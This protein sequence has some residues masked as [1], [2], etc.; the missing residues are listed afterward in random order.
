M[1]EN[2][3]PEQ[4]DAVQTTEGALLVLAGA[5]T[6]KTRV[7]T[8]RIA[9]ILNNHLAMPWQV[10][11]MTFTNKAANEMKTRL[12]NMSDGTWFPNGIWCGTFHAICLR[13]L[14]VHAIKVGLQ[15]NF[16]VY[17][18]DDQKSVIKSLVSA[19]TK[20][21]ADYVEEFS[22]IKDK[23]LV[24]LQNK[25]K[26]FN[27]YNAELRR[28]NAVD[29]GDI[30]L[31]VLE[32]FDKYPD[33]LK[34]YQ[35]QFKYIL[36]DEFQ[37][38]NN[39]QMEFLAMLTRDIENPNIC[40]VG[41]DDQSIYSWRGAEIK[42]IL[43]FQ[44][45]YSNAQIIRLETNYRSTANILGAANS[46]IKHNQGRLGKVLH[47]ASTESQGEPVYV[48]TLP[49]D[50]DEA[51]VIADAILRDASDKFD[52]F[53]V[54]IRSGNLSRVIEEE[55]SMR[56]V[57]YRLIGAT[58][59]YDRMEIRDVIAYLRLLVYPFDDVSFLRVIG[60]PKRGFGNGAIEKMRNTGQNLMQAIKNIA[61]TKKQQASADE[62]LGAFDF[63]WNNMSPSDAAQTLIERSGYLKMWAESKDS[64]AP[65]RLINIK[66]LITSVISKYDTLPE[67]LE[68]AALMTTD[69][70]NPD[71]AQQNN[72]DAVSIMTIHAAKGLEFDTVFLPAW[73]DGIF[74]NDKAIG[75]GAIEEERRLAYVAITRARKRCVISNAMSRMIFGS[76][77]YNSPSRFITEI[78]N[79]FLDFQGGAP[80]KTYYAPY[81][82]NIPKSYEAP[83]YNS[84]PK[85]VVKK[86]E[87]MV[88]KLV[89][90][91]E[92][93]SGVVIE[94][95][96][97]IL[98]IAFKSKGIKKVARE[99]VK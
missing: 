49:T 33:I 1:L 66:E 32:L 58:K 42:H 47:H 27:A 45:L 65:D 63:D 92:L 88:G 19:S 90:H 36:V 93:G 76:R 38:T 23:G 96:G 73:E 30:I 85:P 99:F 55:F 7:L 78:D 44:K 81:G 11:A 79:K 5:G 35:N 61:L 15:Q 77:Q 53:A 4:R 21:P 13:I 12:M 72:T 2:L 9:Y 74:P 26:L 69:D 17:G 71:K 56:G 50:R 51:H 41:D 54:L 84:A 43:N 25:D 37:D 89:T 64:D 82:G 34:S 83:R 10:L 62:F 48:L 24:A 8:T 67:F 68:A 46:L 87:S 97:A 94:D 91:D 98:T 29:F 6:G 31:K 95:G 75:E 70:D 18:E 57:P 22:S 14:R 60:K 28:L 52:K 16:L 59:F 39:A 20:S 40:C 86:I 80:R 3:N